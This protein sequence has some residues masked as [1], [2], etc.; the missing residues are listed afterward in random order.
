MAVTRPVAPPAGRMLRLFTG[1]LFLAVAISTVLIVVT[2]GLRL[3]IRLPRFGI[4]L[5]TVRLA[6]T[7]LVS[8]LAYLRYSLSGAWSWLLIA[9]AFVVLGLNQ[10]TLG[11]LIP[12]ERLGSRFVVYA[13]TAGRIM[14][15]ALLV[16]SALRGSRRDIGPPPRPLGRMMV[17]SGL[18]VLTLAA[19]EGSMWASRAAL[20]PLFTSAGP[21]RAE[22][23]TGALPGLRPISI[24]LAT[25]GASLFLLAAALYLRSPIERISTWLSPALILAAFSNVHYMLLPAVFPQRVSTADFLR[26]AFSVVLLVGVSREVRRA[27][28][29]ERIRG[30][31]LSEAYAVEQ[32]RARELEDLERS[33]AEL[34]AVLTHELMHPV[35]AIRGMAV[36]L[37]QLWDRLDEASRLEFIRRIGQQS[38][39][40]RDLAQEAATAISLESET[41][42]L[43][44]RDVS[45][46][47]LVHQAAEEAADLGGRLRVTVDQGAGDAT[48]RADP[49]R[50]QQVFRNL[51]SNAFK[52]GDAEGP[53]EIHLSSSDGELVFSVT[54]AGP[55]INPESVPQLFQRFTRIRP[56]GREDVPGSGLGLYISRRI[57]EAHGGRIWV[58]TEVGRGS[59]FNFTVPLER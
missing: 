28:V 32:A 24:A 11:L 9:V 49:A 23:I 12:P 38:A 2:P 17:A 6:V 44:T 4:A 52:Y 1:A 54:D 35:A 8:G 59:T 7:G 3:D 26:L 43:Y 40:L 34:F 30:E 42:R 41:F 27:F 10:L 55:G 47:D 58:D 37:D 14:V 46:I 22:E 18:A 45:A 50:L 16:L 25:V 20:P 19:I 21:L 29:T 13:W 48:L 33:K 31:Q 53:V 36:S 39:T 15:A 57:V 56:T 5:E 51:L